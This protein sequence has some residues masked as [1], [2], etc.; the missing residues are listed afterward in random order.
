MD[1]KSA[2]GGKGEAAGVISCPTDS[3]DFHRYNRKK[4]LYATI[5]GWQ[6]QKGYK[7]QK[8]PDAY[9]TR[10]FFQLTS[11]LLSSFFFLSITG[12]SSS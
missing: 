7:I 3:T 9:G 10:G 11:V 5:I 4:G 12:R 6:K 2:A 1:R 8:A